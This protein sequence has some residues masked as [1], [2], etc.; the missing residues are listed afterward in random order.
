MVLKRRRHNTTLSSVCWTEF[1]IFGK[2]KVKQYR[3]YLLT[4]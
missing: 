2:G 3:S 4:H 1:N